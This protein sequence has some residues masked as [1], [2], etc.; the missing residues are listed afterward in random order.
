LKIC[1]LKGGKG[2]DAAKTRGQTMPPTLP[3]IGWRE[4]VNLVSFDN[5]PV[6]AKV[7]T[8]A[9]TSALHAYYVEA[10][11][12]DGERWVRF[13]IHPLQ[14]TTAVARTC[15]AKVKDQRTVRDSGG[16]TEL[17]YVIETEL[18][19]NGHR[20]VAEVTLTDREN[21]RFRMLLGGTKFNPPAFL[22]VE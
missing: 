2:Y 5:T 4:W 7:D 1:P 8:G 22:P 3:I 21:M 11:E 12:R 17:R 16:H 18:Q 9:K 15:E 10:F 14:D 20:F 13:G 6:K 19:L